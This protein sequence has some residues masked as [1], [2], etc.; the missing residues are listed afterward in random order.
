[1]LM[2]HCVVWNGM[3]T[4]GL[5][6]YDPLQEAGQ[7]FQFVLRQGEK[8]RLETREHMRI[9][10][11][12]RSADSRSEQCS[13]DVDLQTCCI[14]IVRHLHVDLDLHA[15]VILG[16]SHNPLLAE[17]ISGYLDCTAHVCQATSALVTSL[18]PKS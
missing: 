8:C 14:D 10:D 12:G 3:I 4:P 13:I 17:W 2:M 18:S 7:G 11:K 16:Q 15:Q 1:M 5:A 9:G 6:E